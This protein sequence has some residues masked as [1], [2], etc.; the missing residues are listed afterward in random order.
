MLLFDVEIAFLI[1]FLRSFLEFFDVFYQVFQAGFQLFQ[2][3]NEIF[4]FFQGIPD[5]FVEI[6][7]LVAVQN[8]LQGVICIFEFETEI[9]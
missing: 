6:F 2:G 9:P 5:I 3:G 8:L 4:G 7:L 1:S